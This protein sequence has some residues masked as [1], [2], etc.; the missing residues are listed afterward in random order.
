MSL[1]I[2]EEVSMMRDGSSNLYALSA[3]EVAQVNAWNNMTD[4]QKGE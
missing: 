4:D 2:H 3:S 1:S